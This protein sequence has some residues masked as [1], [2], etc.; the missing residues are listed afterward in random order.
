MGNGTEA[1]SMNEASRI[2]QGPRGSRTCWIQWVNLKKR[3]FRRV[4]PFS[5]QQIR[6]PRARR[7]FD[8]PFYPP[9][10][11]RRAA[12]SAVPPAASSRLQPDCPAGSGP[13]MFPMSRK[14]PGSESP[15]ESGVG[16]RPASTPAP[17][18]V[19]GRKP[20]GLP[21]ELR[22]ALQFPFR[23]WLPQALPLRPRS[24]LRLR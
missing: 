16:L 15:T 6:M 17:L 11:Q 22:L 5:H 3:D 14:V 8:A 13:V 10:D 4:Q 24:G 23:R 7:L 21:R 9:A 1:E 19:S 2:P 18:P 20:P 12:G